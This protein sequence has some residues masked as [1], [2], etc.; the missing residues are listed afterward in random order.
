MTYRARIGVCCNAYLRISQ[1]QALAERLKLPFTQTTADLPFDYLLCYTTDR[2]ELRPQGFQAINPVAVDFL[3]GRLGYRLL[4]ERSKRQPLAKAMGLKRASKPKVIDATAGTGRDALVL[5]LLGCQVLMMER[6]P[7]I[8]ALLS[9]GL[10]RA[11]KSATLS[12][13]IYHRVNLKC[14]DAI[15]YLKSLPTDERP[16]I[17]YLDPMYPPRKKSAEIKKEMRILR[18]IVGDDSD[19]N[20]LLE[21]AL[22]C[23]TGRVV[24]KRPRLTGPLPGPTPSAIVQG[25]T[26]RYDIYLL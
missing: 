26:T 11:A 1:A 7:I 19:A 21:S 8:A 4:H 2:L 12:E 6:S 17:V 13:L 16:D 5:A 14:S 24:A 10:Q 15:T 20:A 23:A 22:A 9:D 25:K 18:D 3:S